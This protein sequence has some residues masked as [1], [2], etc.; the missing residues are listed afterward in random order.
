[1]TGSTNH[2]QKALE[3][4]VSFLRKRIAE[5]PEIAVVAGSGLGEPLTRIISIHDEIPYREIP[6][7]PVSTVSGHTGS[8]IIGSVNDR[9]ILLFSGRKHLYE[10]APLW[11][12]VFPVLVVSS[13]KIS[14]LIL[15]NAAG[16]LN[17]EF[18]VGDLML[19]TEG[20]NL[21]FKPFTPES[22]PFSEEM[23]RLD[24]SRIFSPEWR[25]EAVEIARNKHIYVRQGVYIATSGPSYETPAEVGYLRYIGGD[26]IGMSTVP[27]AMAAAALGVK[28]IGISFITNLLA[29][30]P[31][32]KTTH[33]E[34]LESSREA[35]PRLARLIQS[36]IR[37]ASS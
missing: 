9:I 19:I 20:V 14:R 3:R 5:K 27:E 34:V 11:H 23:F 31:L 30:I 33:S 22:F 37:L 18:N 2:I 12:A 35:G 7:F 32:K 24:A 21:L 4:T 28:V 25:E 17:P 6:E 13:L 29:E 8:L 16:G 15:T 1:M 36:I 26:A 10:G